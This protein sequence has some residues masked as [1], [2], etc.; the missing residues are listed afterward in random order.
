MKRKSI[1]KALLL[2]V[3]MCC[4]TFALVACGGKHTVTFNYG[5]DGNGDGEVDVVTVEVGDGSLLEEPTDVPTRD[6]YTFVGWGTDN[7][8][9]NFEEDTV[10][11]D[12]TLNARWSAGDPIDPGTP[13][14]TVYVNYAL[15]VGAADSD[16]DSDP[17]FVPNRWFGAPGTTIKLPPAP[18][19][20][21]G[22]EFTGWL[23]EKETELRAAGSDYTVTGTVTI[24]AQWKSL[25]K[26]SPEWDTDGL[27][28]DRGEVLKNLVGTYTPAGG[29]DI[30]V[31]IAKD[32]LSAAMQTFLENAEEE[33]SMATTPETGAFHAEEKAPS[34]LTDGTGTLYYT[35]YYQVPETSLYVEESVAVYTFPISAQGHFCTNWNATVAPTEES[36]GTAQSVCTTCGNTVSVTLPKFTESNVVTEETEPAEG[37]YFKETKQE[38]TCEQ[39]GIVDYQY[40]FTSSDLTN[41]KVSTSDSTENTVSFR[42]TTPATGHKITVNVTPATETDP[43]T[44]TT[45]TLQAICANSGCDQDWDTA[46]AQAT[47]TFDLGSG[48][49]QSNSGVTLEKEDVTFNPETEQFTVTLPNDDAMT[50]IAGMIFTG[51]KV[52][53]TPYAADSTISVAMGGTIAVTGNFT[54]HTHNYGEVTFEHSGDN[55]GK[56]V[57]KCGE[58]GCPEPTVVV[59]T[60]DGTF[61]PEL[62]NGTSVPIGHKLSAGDFTVEVVYKYQIAWEGHQIGET[63]NEK[64]TPETE[65]YAEYFSNNLST[66]STAAWASGLQ[67]TFEFKVDSETVTSG[68]AT[69]DVVPAAD[70][71]FG[72]GTGVQILYNKAGD[73]SNKQI[74]ASYLNGV[75][76][77]GLSVSFW[78]SKELVATNADWASQVINNSGLIVTLPNLD[79]WNNTASGAED[80]KGANKIPAVGTSLNGGWIYSVYL[81]NLSYVT[82][83]LNADG[84]IDYYKNGVNVVSY[85]ASEAI[86]KGTVK[87]F[88]DVLLQAMTETGFA[89]AGGVSANNL[90]VT[91]ALDAANAQKIYDWYAPIYLSELVQ[92]DQELQSTVT[93]ALSGVTV[94]GVNADNASGTIMLS[95]SFSDVQTE[96]I[97]ATYYIPA[98]SVVGNDWALGMQSGAFAVT[99]G[100]LDAATSTGDLRDARIYCAAAD[101][102]ESFTGDPGAPWLLYSEG[103]CYVTITVVDG[104]VEFYKNGNLELTFT[105]AKSLEDAG[106]DSAVTPTGKTVAD[107]VTAFLGSVAENGMQVGGR[108]SGTANTWIQNAVVTSALDAA[109]V[110]TLYDTISAQN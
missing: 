52:G 104:K 3:L 10:T 83:T 108:A 48:N 5:V 53:D 18:A 95:S 51:W 105:S 85:G 16:S 70:D 35:V 49:V 93:G 19:A 44:V 92:A 101:Q 7:G 109:Q 46:P 55:A 59:A 76:T 23:V 26:I 94:Y 98:G 45:A 97:S 79:P 58:D 30:T 88:T 9:W 68:T 33:G 86:G 1:L 100:I 77:T 82:I 81:G 61:N 37:Y 63:Y 39:D 40:M 13:G 31:T 103:N 36:T 14:T 84:S 106:L 38:L 72:A 20:D 32:V 22:W 66:L 64:I 12:L 25:T 90:L 56:F 8:M 89:F 80:I 78:L 47:V 110:K 21:A 17:S 57:A 15:G 24:T 73:A 71:I 99:Q 74:D 54:K 87:T 67:A 65:D 6:G 62:K 75:N 2:T 43:N 42:V 34:C 27:I 60:T 29:G 96:G 91:T 50:L 28:D 4:L 102:S 11:S 107:F 41:A 69:F